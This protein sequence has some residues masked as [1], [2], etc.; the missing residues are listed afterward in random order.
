MTLPRAYATTPAMQATAKRALSVVRRERLE[1][2]DIDN[3]IIV[4]VADGMDITP[5]DVMEMYEFFD[6]SGYLEAGAVPPL[7]TTTPATIVANLY[8]GTNGLQWCSRIA[9][10]IEKERT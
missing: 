7:A 8:G 2:E 5:R 4:G 9:R 6:K 3:A 10:Q 1:S